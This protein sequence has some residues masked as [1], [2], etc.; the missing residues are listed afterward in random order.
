MNDRKQFPSAKTVLLLG[1]ACLALLWSVPIHT[2]R[3][4]APE[5]G[6]STLGVVNINTASV[7]TL[8]LLPGVG[9]VVA[10]AILF[11]REHRGGFKRIE[12]LARVRGIG[13]SLLKKLRPHVILVGRSTA[14][15]EPNRSDED[16]ISVTR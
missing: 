10:Q 15:L 8:Q 16:G 11:E 3:A 13:P 5:P 6:V 12:D 7:D 2:A 4:G 9:P 1:G 14:L